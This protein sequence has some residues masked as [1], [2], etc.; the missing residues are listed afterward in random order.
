[1]P[2][3]DDE[4]GK[5]LRPADNS[6]H[7]AGPVDL[8]ATAESGKL[9]LDG[10]AI[11]AEQPFPNVF[12][13]ILKVSPGLHSVVLTWEG[14]RKE[15]RFFVGANP[16]AG[17]QAFHQHPPVPGVQCTQCHELNARGRFAFKG[18]CFD[19]HQ[20][21]GFAKIHTHEPAVL[22]QCGICHNAHGSTV[23]AHLVYSKENACKIC[24]N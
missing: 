3:A 10:A 21:T 1:M 17:F 12:H 9:Q 11:Q 24:H 8:V 7:Q 14:G 6:W 4:K 15:V 5:I 13:T 19:C 16:P 2:A 22:E 20:K 23:K 18:G